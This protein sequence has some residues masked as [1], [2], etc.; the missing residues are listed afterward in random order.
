MKVKI[1][2]QSDGMFRSIS[3]K[4]VTYGD[5]FIL[6]HALKAYPSPEAEKIANE[7]QAKMIEESMIVPGTE[8]V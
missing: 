8:R 2:K 1:E 6:L 4:N 3:F 5:F 7:L